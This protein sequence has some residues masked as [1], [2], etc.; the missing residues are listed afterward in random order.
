MEHPR[1]PRLPRR[2]ARHFCSEIPA[3]KNSPWVTVLQTPRPMLADAAKRLL[4]RSGIEARVAV[5]EALDHLPDLMQRR[6]VTVQVRIE[7]L[8]EAK[9]LLSHDVGAQVV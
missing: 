1:S 5:V 6:E 9:R 8:A 7:R 4:E 2:E 3:M